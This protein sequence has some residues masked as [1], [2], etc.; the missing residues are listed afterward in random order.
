MVHTFLLIRMAGPSPEF[1][2]RHL[3]DPRSLQTQIAS[4]VKKIH[5][6]VGVGGCALSGIDVI[7]VFGRRR[8][9]IEGSSDSTVFVR[10]IMRVNERETSAA[11]TMSPIFG[12]RPCRVDVLQVS[13][14]LISLA[15]PSNDIFPVDWTGG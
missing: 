1:A 13:N 10:A 2:E 3:S 15:R 8:E 5:G 11:L 9:E 6:D 4:N 12:D 7:K 14:R